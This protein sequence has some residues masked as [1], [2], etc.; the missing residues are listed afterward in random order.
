MKLVLNNTF[1]TAQGFRQIHSTKL[2]THNVYQ[3]AGSEQS[4]YR[5]KVGE[6]SVLLEMLAACMD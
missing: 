5:G 3:G 2:I 4:G 6:I 1:K